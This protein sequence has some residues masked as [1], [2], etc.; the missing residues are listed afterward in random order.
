[1]AFEPVEPA[2]HLHECLALI[3]AFTA[4]E[5]PLGSVAEELGEQAWRSRLGGLAVD[6]EAGEVAVALEALIA[7]LHDFDVP[8]AQREYADLVV[9]AAGVGVA[10][11]GVVCL[12]PLVG[13]P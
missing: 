3:R 1:M 9:L 7:N 8:L 11:E 10:K 2:G 6:A 5:R 13:R 12:A 4:A